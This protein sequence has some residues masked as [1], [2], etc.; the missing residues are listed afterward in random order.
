MMRRLALFWPLATALLLTALMR[1]AL[2]AHPAE[3]LVI[4]T[5]D[6]VLARLKADSERLKGDASLIYPLVEDLVLPHFD[7]ERMSIWVL[8]KNWRGAD[9][10]QQQQFTTEFRT[11]LVRTYAKALLEYT[12]Q[13]LRYLPFHAEEGADRVTVKTEIEQSGGPSIPL[14]YSMYLNK[15]GEWKVYDIKVD[16]ISLV[17]NYRSSF[18]TEIRNGGI[19]RLLDKLVRMNQGGDPVEGGPQ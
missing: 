9:K 17:S 4:D 16:G 10:A 8:G 12:D 18:A 1:P 2:A 7:F 15:G 6:R 11:L 19:P 14:H 5:T 13:Q 3:Q